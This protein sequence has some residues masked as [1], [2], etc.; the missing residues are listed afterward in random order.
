[1]PINYKKINKK[2]YK[3]INANKI[4]NV[5]YIKI[6]SIFKL[7]KSYQKIIKLKPNQVD[8]EQVVNYINLFKYIIIGI[9]IDKLI[10]IECILKMMV[11]HVRNIHK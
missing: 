4:N 5:N 8:Y 9:I 2:N 3:R 11:E 1:M 7:C 10:L 6:N